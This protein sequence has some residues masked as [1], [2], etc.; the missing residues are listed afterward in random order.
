MAPIKQATLLC[1]YA[2]EKNDFCVVSTTL[3][4]PVFHNN[5]LVVGEPSIRSYAGGPVRRQNGLKVGAICAVDHKER[6]STKDQLELLGGLAQLMAEQIELRQIATTDSL[7]GALIR[8]AFE[9]EVTREYRR[10]V[11]ISEI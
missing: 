11:A 9:V 1:D 10:K 4:H 5:P 6:D 7:T 3:E 2:F 8:R